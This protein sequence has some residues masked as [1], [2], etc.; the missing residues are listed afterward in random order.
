M[1]DSSH[2]DHGL[3]TL[4]VRGAVLVLGFAAAMACKEAPPAETALPTASVPPASAPLAST[5]PVSANAPPAKAAP[6]TC[7]GPY[8]SFWSDASNTPPPGAPHVFRLSQ[9]FPK[10]LPAAGAQPWLAADPFS[11]KTLEQR[12][13]ESGKY[14]HAVLEYIFEG[15]VGATPSDADFSLCSNAVRPWFHVPWMDA[16]PSKGREYVH[17]MTRELAPSPQKLGPGQVNTEAA[18]AVGFYNERGAFAIGE[19]FPGANAKDVKAPAQSMHFADGSVVGKALFTTATPEALPYLKGSPRWQA[20]ILPPA[21]GGRFTGTAKAPDGS[22]VNCTRTLHDVYLAQFDVAVVDARAPLKWVFGTFVYDG[23]EDA[24]LGW[25]GLRPVGLMWGNDP[26][27]EPKNT[28][29]DANDPA[30]RG[31]TPPDKVA[32]SFMFTDSMPPW[33]RKDLGCAGR[34]DGPIDNPRSSCMSCHA[35]ASSPLLIATG[36]K[37]PCTGTTVTSATV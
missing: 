9:A 21:C 36:Q 4:S 14:I 20:N 22:T 23:L 19:V 25:R 11:A 3:G 26:G 27:L 2:V 32:Q 35:S 17:G 13:V 12:G 37:N 5:P 16:N 30:K 24:S 7:V 33:L 18:W 1:A 6:N 8:A 10:A 29:P 31:L 34:L 15:N 28:N